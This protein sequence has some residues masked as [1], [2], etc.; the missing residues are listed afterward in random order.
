LAP[1]CSEQETL[2]E[3]LGIAGGVSSESLSLA[4]SFLLPTTLPSP[5]FT[6]SRNCLLDR[7]DLE[8]V[9]VAQLLGSGLFYFVLSRGRRE[10]GETGLRTP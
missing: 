2:R 8:S 6:P 5:T 7:R 3:R 9:L 4:P 10:V 1:T